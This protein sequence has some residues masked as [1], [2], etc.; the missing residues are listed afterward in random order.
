M[1]S[2]FLER[3]ERLDPELNCYLT[4]LADEALELAR[5]YDRDKGVALSPLAAIP[6]AIKDVICMQGIRTTSRRASWKTSLPL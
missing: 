4:S 6:L 5:Q 2:A 1:V 3:I